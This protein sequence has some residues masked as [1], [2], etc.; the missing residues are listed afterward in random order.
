MALPQNIVTDPSKRNMNTAATCL[1][2]IEKIKG[3]VAEVGGVKEAFQVYEFYVWGRVPV[4]PGPAGKL[5]KIGAINMSHLEL[6]MHQSSCGPEFAKACFDGTDVG[7]ATLT[8][9]TMVGGELKVLYTIELTNCRFSVV[10][11]D[12]PYDLETAQIQPLSLP[13]TTDKEN[14]RAHIEAIARENTA[15]TRQFHNKFI[16]VRMAYDT[17]NTTYTTYEDTGQSAGKT[18]TTIDLVKNTV[19]A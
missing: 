12:V 1:L 16:K 8:L 5:E 15:V 18:A 19:K 2:T 9:L 13:E 3:P 17:F 4:A 14:Y 7:K 11:L 10:S 6:V